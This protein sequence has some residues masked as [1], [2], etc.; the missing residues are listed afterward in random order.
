[1]SVQV[2]DHRCTYTF[3]V[4][5]EQIMYKQSDIRVRAKSSAFILGTVVK[6]AT[7]VYGPTILYG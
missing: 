7:N 6:T 2:Y 4:L 1:M 5:L 3:T